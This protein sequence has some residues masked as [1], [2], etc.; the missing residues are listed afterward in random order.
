[1]AARLGRMAGMATE[2][3]LAPQY[4]MRTMVAPM[5]PTPATVMQGQ[6]SQ[7]QKN[8]QGIVNSQV[9]RAIPEDLRLAEL[10]LLQAGQD[11]QNTQTR[12]FR[13]LPG[14][15]EGIYDLVRS[16][17]AKSAYVDARDNFGKAN[18]AYEQNILKQEADQWAKIRNEYVKS[19]APMIEPNMPVIKGESPEQRTARAEQLAAVGFMQ[20]KDIKSL[21]PDGPPAP[22]AEEYLDPT[23]GSTWQRFRD[24]RTGNVMTGDQYKP[25]MVKGPEQKT[26]G[27]DYMTVEEVD[28]DGT[29]TAVYTKPDAQG[30]QTLLNR[31]FKKPPEPDASQK[32]SPVAVMPGE[33]RTKLLLTVSAND[34]A[35]QALPFLFNSKGSFNRWDAKTPGSDA[36]ANLNSYRTAVSQ[37][38][39]QETGASKSPSE[40]E[41]MADSYTPG[42][43]DS[44]TMAM[45]KV[46]D[47]MEYLKTLH[48]GYTSGYTGLPPEMGFR[49][50]ALPWK[51][52]APAQQAA[53]VRQQNDL[54]ARLN[55]ALIA[56]GLQVPGAQQ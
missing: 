38:L 34:K 8:I 53:V 52:T 48:V 37:I 45:K 30:K 13:G 12:R 56:A 24:Q 41:D 32:Q 55:A 16:K 23:T 35:A 18:I 36:A 28:K 2:D 40:I 22:V 3:A 19:A 6:A 26:T 9:N 33:Q 50:G 20:G 51:E 1:M 31:I 7:S 39:R 42:F 27:V 29:W 46:Q 54:D 17:G 49:P 15:G 47:F 25:F 21:V 11:L 4:D 10:E 44:D 14:L 43:N 5:Q